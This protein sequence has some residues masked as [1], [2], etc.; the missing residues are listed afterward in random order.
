MGSSA[1]QCNFAAIH[2]EDGH[3]LQSI[4][5]LSAGTVLSLLV[6]ACRRLVGATVYG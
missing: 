1:E 4:S 5:F 6:Q 3:S 2:R